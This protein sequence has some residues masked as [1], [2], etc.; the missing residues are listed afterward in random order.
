MTTSSRVG[1]GS[2]LLGDLFGT[3][4]ARRAFDDQALI[5]G[6]LDAERALA[7]AQ[8]EV[9]VVPQAAAERIAT[10]ADAANFDTAELKRGIADSAHPLVPFVRALGARCGEEAGAWVHWGATTQDIID[11][12][13]V[14][15]IRTALTPI[16]RDLVRALAAARS[17][18][19]R[20]AD[21]PEAGR[22]H[23]QHAVP[24]TFGLKAASWADE[25]ARAAE[26]L[27]RAR[28]SVLTGQLAGA[29]GTLASL[30]E[31]AAAVRAAFCRQLELAEPDVPWHTARDRL[32]ELVHAL[33]QI[34]GAG[35]RI[36]AEVVRLQSTEIGEAFE[37]STDLSVGSST[38]P[39]KRNPMVCEYVIACAR[40]QRG[41]LAVLEASAAHASE[42]DMG[43][44]A[45]EW[46][47]IP[48]AMILTASLLD[49]LAA[50]LEGLVVDPERMRAN[51]DLTDGAIMAEAVMMALGRT[52]GHEP[53][54][55]AVTAASKRAARERT[56]LRD[57][58]LADPAVTGAIADTELD[59]LLDPSRYLGLAAEIATTVANASKERYGDA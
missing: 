51:I 13:A 46:L 16:A 26:R 27:D 42:R 15:Q 32:R 37:P 18:A 50:V 40:L 8:A 10:E 54:H 43:L 33:V 38:M 6:W 44:W 24:V 23:Q 14:L 28:S 20:Y 21:A 11:T 22:T 52:M 45:P 47:A 55:R 53:A 7:L 39:Q 2:E 58:L 3:E 31:D 29:A 41:P 57:A 19:G 5:Q 17:L 56:S 34:G 1:L 30:G 9:G 4:E 49:K 48:E 36:A 59:E 35:E 12:G 25:L